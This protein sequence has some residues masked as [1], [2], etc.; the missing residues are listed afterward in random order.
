MCLTGSKGGRW[1][2]ALLSIL[3]ALAVLPVVFVIV[4]A[5]L[6]PGSTE[7]LFA[8]IYSGGGT[9]KYIT[10]RHIEWNLGQFYAAFLATPEYW[11]GFWNSVF[12]VVPCLLGTLIVSILSGY[13][14]AKFRFRGKGLL[15]YLFLTVMLLPYQVRLVPDFFVGTTLGLIGNRLAVILPNIFTP[16]GCYLLFLYM[17]KIP[18]ASMEAA[19]VEGAGS[20]QILL[21]VVLPQSLPGVGAL[22]ILTLI[23]LWNSVEQPLILLRDEAKYPLSVELQRIGAEEIGISF[24]CA[25]VYMIPILLSFLAGK[26]SMTKGIE[27]AYTD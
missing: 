3:T 16:F 18:D 23:D 12:L 14:F 27:N 10:L 25:A 26:D 7:A 20:F 21:R 13:A 22:A 11:L 1:K 17:K 5:F 9:E 19:R 4:C 15:F 2:T 6:S 24:A 8:D